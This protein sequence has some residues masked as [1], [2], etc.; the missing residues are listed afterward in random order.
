MSYILICTS[1]QETPGW[2]T[3]CILRPVLDPG[4]ATA[5]ASV[6]EITKQRALPADMRRLRSCCL[7]L[8]PPL[9]APSCCPIAS[10]SHLQTSSSPVSELQKHK[11]EV[12]LMKC[13]AACHVLY[14][15]ATAVAFVACSF[16]GARGFAMGSVLGSSHYCRCNARAVFLN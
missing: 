16:D 12:K 2:Q 6:K 13:L 10:H 9:A 15:T 7:L 11:N 4:R 1:D 3:A 8:L 5:C 14:P